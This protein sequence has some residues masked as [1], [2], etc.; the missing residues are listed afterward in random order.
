MS[1]IVD[2]HNFEFHGAPCARCGLD[3]T[4]YDDMPTACAGAPVAAL[5]PSSPIGRVV[6]ARS[7][8][9]ALSQKPA[10]SESAAAAHCT[11]SVQ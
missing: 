3:E 4:E 9:P 11:T 7:I 10:L 5:L 6:A 2:G 1:R 8:K